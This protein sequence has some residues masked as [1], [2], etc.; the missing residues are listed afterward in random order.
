[1]LKSDPWGKNF[2]DTKYGNCML[3]W[4]IDHQVW[5]VWY[6]HEA[7]YYEFGMKPCIDWIRTQRIAGLLPIDAYR[8]FSNAK[9]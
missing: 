8:E 5:R 9:R 1:M 3:K 6:C 4:D 7:V 2:K